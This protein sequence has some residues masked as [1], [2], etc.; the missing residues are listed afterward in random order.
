MK[1]LIL[2]KGYISTRC[3]DSWPD[4]DI[5]TDRI[6]SIDDAL[7]ILEQNQPD[8]VLNAIGIKGKPN[9]DWCETHQEETMWG[10]VVVPIMIAKACQEKNIYLLHI[11]SGCVYYGDSPSPNG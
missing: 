10:N 4:A 3:A 2:G 5:C 11:G 1:I 9:V 6:N 7:Q 8:V